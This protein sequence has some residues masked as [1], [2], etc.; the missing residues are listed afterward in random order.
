MVGIFRRLLK[1]LTIEYAPWHVWPSRLL[2]FYKIIFQSSCQRSIRLVYRLLTI[3]AKQSYYDCLVLLT[4][5]SIHSSEGDHLAKPDDVSS[6]ASWNCQNT[7]ID[8][9]FSFFF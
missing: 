3:R 8:A 9:A 6:I 4:V 7:E 2:L 1:L 5:N